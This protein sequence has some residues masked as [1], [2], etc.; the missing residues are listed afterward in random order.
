MSIID[1]LKSLSQAANQ[2]LPTL[3]VHDYTEEI[4]KLD[5]NELP[6]N[7]LPR[8]LKD[9]HDSTMMHCYP[10]IGRNDNL[11]EEELLDNTNIR[12]FLDNL[13]RT[14]D[15][16]TAKEFSFID[17]NPIKT[18]SGYFAE[19]GLTKASYTLNN[20][21]EFALSVRQAYASNP[22][23]T[24]AGCL[25]SI[26]IF[27]QTPP[28]EIPQDDLEAAERLSEFCRI[29]ETGA[30]ATDKK[31]KLYTS[32]VELLKGPKEEKPHLIIMASITLLET[33]R[34]YKNVLKSRLKHHAIRKIVFRSLQ[35]PEATCKS[36]GA[37]ALNKNCT[38]SLHKYESRAQL[39]LD[40]CLN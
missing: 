20:I 28:E 6:L 39:L 22:F 29:F 1:T 8:S 13:K 19:Y 4:G 2:I 15:R 37:K 5:E 11:L 24:L 34:I 21:C 16:C 36:Y 26:N 32:F 25:P 12:I 33:K 38:Q 9:I 40:Q 14:N 7:L 17:I 18:I 10:I 3:E 23:G 31:R 27:F 30:Y 35:Q